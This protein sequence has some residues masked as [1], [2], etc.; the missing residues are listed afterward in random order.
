MRSQA[1]RFTLGMLA[2]AVMLL[3]GAPGALASGFQSGGG[4]VQL[5]PPTLIWS[6]TVGNTTITDED[7]FLGF[8]GTIAGTGTITVLAV[9]HPI[10]GENFVGNWSAPAS[11]NGR[12][13]TV[14]VRFLG[15]DNGTFSGTLLATG[16]KGLAGFFAEGQFSGDDATGLGTYTIN[17]IDP[18]KL[19]KMLER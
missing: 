17:C 6:K 2:T 1:H 15:T 18:T 9:V 16:S 8:T 11:V 12:T 14:T 10:G 19:A 4:S 3:A 7:G 5:G 13:G